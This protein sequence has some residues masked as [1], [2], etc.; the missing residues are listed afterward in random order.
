MLQKERPT[1]PDPKTTDQKHSHREKNLFMST[2]K[3]GCWIHNS[4]TVG[5]ALEAQVGV[6][7]TTSRPNGGPAALHDVPIQT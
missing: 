4:R 7:L 6:Y 3:G 5:V 1:G 2:L